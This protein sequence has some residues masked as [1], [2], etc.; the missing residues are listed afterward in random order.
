MISAKSRGRRYFEIRRYVHSK[1]ELQLKNLTNKLI[2]VT[3]E[4]C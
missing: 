3:T 2:G 1:Q 4:A